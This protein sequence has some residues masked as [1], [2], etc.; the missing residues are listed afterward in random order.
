[1]NSQFEARAITALEALEKGETVETILR[2]Y[3]EDAAALRP[4]LE[5]ARDLYALPLAYAVSAKQAARNEMLNEAKRLRSQPAARAVLVPAMRRLSLAVATLALLLLVAVGLLAEPATE[6]VPGDPLYP[7]KR[8]G[9]EVRLRLAADP[10]ALE[11]RY[12]QERRRELLTLLAE[13]REAEIDCF[14]TI[15]SVAE[16][17]WQLDDLTLFIVADSVIS[18]VPAPGAPVEGM[19]RVR[20]GQLH[21]LHLRITGPGD[22]LPPTVTPTPTPTVEQSQATPAPTATLEPTPTPT[23][24]LES[25]AVIPA[26]NPPPAPAAGEDE[27]DDDNGDDDDDDDDDGDEDDED[28]DDDDDGD[29]EDGDDDGEGD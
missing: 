2:R 6:A 27:S 1:M 22:P 29:E 16:D 24:T 14:G 26:E 5:T 25:P 19:C 13:G 20:D 18:G 7:L 3:P 21:A 11:A 10:V 4:L 28:G 8:A 23:P 9:E 15:R 17:R 12:R